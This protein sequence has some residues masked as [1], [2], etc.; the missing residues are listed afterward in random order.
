MKTVR[1][2]HAFATGEWTQKEDP[3]GLFEEFANHSVAILP[4]HTKEERK[5]IATLELNQNFNE[6]ELNQNY[7]KLA[8]KYH[9][10]LNH[11]NNKAEDMIKEINT[12]YKLLKKKFV[13]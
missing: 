7:R 10:D 3:F 11:N 4:L 13:L 6:E 5:A 9:P 12:A 8:K 1:V 2:T